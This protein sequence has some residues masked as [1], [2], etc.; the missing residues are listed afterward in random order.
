M[1]VP[2][3]DIDP[4]KE[5]GCEQNDAPPAIKKAYYKL[6][7]KYHPDKLSEKDQVKYKTKFE[8]I[9][10]SYQVLGD[11]K[12]RERYD[13]TGNLD[14]SVPDDDDFDWYSFF[15]EMRNSDVKVTSELIQ[16]DKE[17]YQESH[18]EYEDVLETMIYYQGDFLK[19]FETIPHLEFGDSEEARMYKLV[20]QMVEAGDLQD[21]KRWQ[22]YVKNRV[23]EKK[24]LARKLRNESDE[25]EEALK[26]INEKNKHKLDGSEDSLRQLIQS[27]KSHTFDDLIA[28]YSQPTKATKSKTKRSKPSE[29]DLDDS[30]FDKIQQRLKKHKQK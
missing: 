14:E 21:Y 13:R 18:E 7:L 26:E 28:K 16:K 19:L 4:Y 10:F 12:R 29:Y 11:Q 3:P 5:L 17:S 22:K 27:K 30:E 1:T 23:S 15:Q 24:K 2:F 25:A 9:Q 8:K 6:C 20:N